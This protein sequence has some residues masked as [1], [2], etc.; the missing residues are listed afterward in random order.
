M[1][2]VKQNIEIIRRNIKAACERSGKNPDDIIIVAVTKK[3]GP[4]K[5]MEAV[6]CGLTCLGESYFQEAKNKILEIKENVSWH[7]IGHLQKNKAAAAVP[8]FDLIHSVDSF[9]LLNKINAK[10]ESINKIQ[11]VLLQLN[12]A[13]EKEK[14]GMQEAEALLLLKKSGEMRNV[15]I[16]G[17]MTIPPLQDNPDN[18]RVY[19][20]KLYELG[21]KIDELKPVNWENKYLSMGMSD[22]YDIAVEEGANMLRIGTAIFGGRKD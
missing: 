17:L 14:F 8:L 1:I 9:E 19:F 18:N 16:L 7:F 15:K 11:N 5:I 10:A 3:V 4:P 20:K 12:V 13:G 6:N 2:G 21:L 22:D